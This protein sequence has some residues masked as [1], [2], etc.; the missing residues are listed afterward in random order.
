MK[1]RTCDYCGIDR[2]LLLACNE[3]NKGEGWICPVCLKE[4]RYLRA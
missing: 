3:I 1:T 4:K 2:V